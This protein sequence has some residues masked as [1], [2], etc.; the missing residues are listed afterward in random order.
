MAFT[1][2]ERGTKGQIQSV[3]V[4]IDHWWALSVTFRPSLSLSLFWE[5]VTI[6]HKQLFILQ[7]LFSDCLTFGHHPMRVRA[8]NCHPRERNRKR[9]MN[10]K[11]P[12]FLCCYFVVLSLEIIINNP[13][14]QKL[15]N[16]TFLLCCLWLQF[17]WSFEPFGRLISASL[18]FV[19]K[20][21]WNCFQLPSCHCWCVRAFWVSLLFLV[22]SQI[23]KGFGHV[24]TGT[25]NEETPEMPPAEVKNRCI[26]YFLNVCW[27]MSVA[28][29]SLDR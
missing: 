13:Y 4:E 5:L 20:Q 28:I 21:H 24:R 18:I 27:L 12:L 7:F 26:V 23:F 9:T 25:T 11:A 2:L 29:V 3:T 17:E 14:R 22:T 10:N 15:Y 19:M 16:W 8:R 6:T 1:L